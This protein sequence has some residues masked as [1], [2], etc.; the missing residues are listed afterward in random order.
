MEDSAIEQALYNELAFYTLAHPSSDFIHQHIVDAFA[1]QY[2]SKDDK[3]I[4]PAFALLGLYLHLHHGYTGKQVQYAHMALAQ[5]RKLWPTFELPTQRGDVTVVHVVAVPPG[6]ERDEMIEAWCFSVWTAYT[7]I[8]TEVAN[9][10]EQ[11][12]AD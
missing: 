1:A 10:W 8:H 5:R 7:A 3:P 4:R 12:M 2:A 9:L 6:K 11:T